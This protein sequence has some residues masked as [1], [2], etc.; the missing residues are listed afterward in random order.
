MVYI[1]AW[2]GEINVKVS[3]TLAS[4]RIE[5]PVRIFLKAL[6][7]ETHMG[8]IISYHPLPCR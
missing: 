6:P 5:K 2:Q 1:D 3:F 7:L 8:V 4:G